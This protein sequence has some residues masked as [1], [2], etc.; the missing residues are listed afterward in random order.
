MLKATFGAVVLMTGLVSQVCAQQWGAGAP[1]AAVPPRVEASATPRH[2]AP[3]VREKAPADATITT[4]HIARL[5]ATLNLTSAQQSLW[6]P[7]EVALSEL[8][9]QQARG[10]DTNAMMAQLRRV[11]AIA[12]PLIKSLDEGQ[13]HSAMTFARNFGFQQ[14]V[15]AF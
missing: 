6:A 14:L 3:A 12:M 9:R 8:A 13:K 4:S 2:P 5:R 1:A 7:V 10:G 11:K 15:T